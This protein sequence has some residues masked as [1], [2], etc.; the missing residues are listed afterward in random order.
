MTFTLIDDRGLP[1]ES[2]APG[3]LGGH[4]GNRVYGRLDCSGALR[5]IER[6]HYV[7]QR[8]FFAD[9]AT[10][11]AA[12]FRPCAACMPAEHARW[13]ARRESR[14]FSLVESSLVGPLL[15]SG[16]EEVLTGLA[17]ATGA[18]VPAGWRRDD[19]RFG[20]ERRQL[21]EYFEGERDAFDIAL[22]P[23][24][25]SFNRRVWDEL[26]AIPHGSTAT[27]G[28]VAER[29][30]APGRGRAVGAAN[31]RN[32]IAVMIPCHRVIGA[33]G[34]LTGYGGGLPA[35]RALLV[36]EGALLDV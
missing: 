22:R 28:E 27:Y 18:G 36:L 15:L 6:G 33:G 31:A 21:G 29:V 2:D 24:G 14:L 12:G 17:F 23:E 10:A 3:T 1:Y 9:E 13:K 19:H 16:D 4:R 32:P 26:L 34:R 7:S 20:A 5:W 35:K 8:V 11:M 25:A 30:G